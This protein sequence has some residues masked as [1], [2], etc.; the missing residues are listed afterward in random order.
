MSVDETA[1]AGGGFSVLLGEAAAAA[2][3][4]TWM[5]DTI[6]GAHCLA[7]S[8]L[9]FLDGA[10]L[11][12]FGTQH[13]NL[14]LLI[15]MLNRAVYL[16]PVLLQLLIDMVLHQD[17]VLEEMQQRHEIAAAAAAKQQQQQQHVHQ[18]KGDT[19]NNRAVSSPASPAVGTSIS[20]NSS[21]RPDTA[22]LSSAIKRYESDEAIGQ[23]AAAAHAGSTLNI[24]SCDSGEA[25]DGSYV[26]QLLRNATA[27]QL[28]LV[29]SWGAEEWCQYWLVSR[30][31]DLTS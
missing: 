31:A 21:S 27:E 20:S 24:N 5:Y 3:R 9:L 16:A 29:Q 10:I 4:D 2:V 22:A 18:N 14:F 12:D 8:Q 1:W 23:A 26:T 15:S 17:M 28:Q 19:G 30:H 7:C 13:T 6:C 11:N 25:S